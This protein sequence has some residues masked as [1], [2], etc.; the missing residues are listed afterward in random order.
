MN[1]QNAAEI[2]NQEWDN[3]QCRQLL[4]ILTGQ[5]KKVLDSDSSRAAQ[6]KD[7]RTL[8]EVAEEI[9]G[10]GIRFESEAREK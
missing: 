3:I 9:S 4:H 5:I 7:I 6:L 2:I 10:C 8:V 1:K